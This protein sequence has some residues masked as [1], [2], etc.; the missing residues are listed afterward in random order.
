MVFTPSH[1]VISNQQGIHDNLDSLIA[2][3]LNHPFQQ[4]VKPSS[5]AIFE[6]VLAWLDTTPYSRVIFDAG[7]GTGQSTYWLAERYPNCAVVGF[8]KSAVRIRKGDNARDQLSADNV[9]IVQADAVDLWVLAA[10]EK[11]TLQRHCLFYPNPWPKKKHLQRRWHGHGVFPALVSLGGT[12]E[13]RSNWKLYLEEFATAVRLATGKNGRLVPITPG[14]N[15][16]TL[17]EQKYQQSGHELWQLCI[18]LD[19]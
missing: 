5:I 8:D 11:L 12:I 17:F 3:H 2:K 9:K 15:P 7:C 16:A 19:A 13:L 4:P 6:E 18:D 1:R 14:D 10:K